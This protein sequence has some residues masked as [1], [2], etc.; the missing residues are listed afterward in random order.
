[1]SR[2]PQGSPESPSSDPTTPQSAAPKLVFGA[3]RKEDGE[4]RGSEGLGHHPASLP[5]PCGAVPSSDEGGGRGA[6]ALCFQGR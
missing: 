1:M 2:G 4:A 6:E 3:L 5:A